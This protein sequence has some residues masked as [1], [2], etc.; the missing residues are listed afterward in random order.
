MKAFRADLH[1]HTLLSPCGDLAMS[2]QN[3]VAAA[4]Q[5]SL[6]II[7]ITDHNSTR[8]CKLVSELAAEVGILSLFGAEITSREEVHCLGLVPDLSSLEKLQSYLDKH[9]A[10]IKNDPDKFGYQVVVDRDENIIYEE[11]RL[12]ISSLNQSID[13]IEKTIHDMGGIFIPAHV[14]RSAFGLISQLG[15]IPDDLNY[16]A[17][18]ISRHT[19]VEKFRKQHSYLK[20]CTII[21]SSDA[22]FPGH[23]GECFTNFFMKNAS[24]DEI[25]LALQNY[26]VESTISDA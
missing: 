10:N 8:H 18:E 5:K 23:I 3:I 26:S 16:D 25:K 15:F 4:R 21:Q 12:L 7:A 9:L 17:L 14:N 1:I 13:E 24:F 20:D 19:T 11:E 22:H 6:D 2:P